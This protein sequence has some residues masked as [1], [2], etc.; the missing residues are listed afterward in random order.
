MRGSRG[1]E[2]IV[3]IDIPRLDISSS[4]LRRRVRAGRSVDF[5]VADAV[6]AYIQQGGLYR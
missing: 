5:L 1:A 6:G 2:R 4:A 3:Y